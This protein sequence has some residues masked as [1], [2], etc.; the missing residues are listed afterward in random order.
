MSLHNLLICGADGGK[1]GGPSVLLVESMD[2]PGWIHSYGTNT[3][4]SGQTFGRYGLLHSSDDESSIDIFKDGTLPPDRFMLRFA[5]H[6]AEPKCSLTLNM[7]GRLITLERKGDSF[8][9]V[10]RSPSG[11]KR[12]NYKNLKL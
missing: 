3:V 9:S 11:G 4:P 6:L 2:M 5:Y 12:Q 7:Q 10:I 8:S 1:T